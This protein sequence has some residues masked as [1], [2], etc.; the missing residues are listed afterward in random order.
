MIARK[1]NNTNPVDMVV[2]ALYAAYSQS[3]HTDSRALKPGDYAGHTAAT[4][5]PGLS[6]ADRKVIC[7]AVNKAVKKAARGD[8][9]P[10]SVLLFE[11]PDYPGS[12]H[13]AVIELLDYVSTN[14]ASNQGRWTAVR[15]RLCTCKE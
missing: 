2:A 7:E 14:P 12:P 6:D 1:L 3:V 4:M 13:L 9:N 8:A 11:I 5:I 15:V 10:E